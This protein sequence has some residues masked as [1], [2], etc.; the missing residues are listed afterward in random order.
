MP[1]NLVLLL[2]FLGSIQTHDLR[3]YHTQG[4]AQAYA[5]IANETPPDSLILG[6]PETGL[7]LPA[8]TGRRV[9]YGHPFETVNASQEEAAVIAFFNDPDPVFLAERGINYVFFGPRERLLSGD[10]VAE[11]EAVLNSFPVAYQTQGVTLY[12]VAP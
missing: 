12:A 4:E 3:I 6:S 1:T 11:L 2:S 7:R 8:Y 9:I 5:W 10:N